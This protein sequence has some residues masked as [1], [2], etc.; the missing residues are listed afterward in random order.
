[1]SRWQPWTT[2]LG[3]RRAVLLTFG[4]L[5]AAGAL[6]ASSR[7]GDW[8]GSW[9]M[10][11]ATGA[12]ATAFVG[13]VA[14]GV[15]CLVYARLRSSAMSEVL[16]QSR[17]DWLRWLQPLLATWLLAFA[18]LVVVT[19]ATT[20]I[21]W[22]SGVPAYPEYLWIVLPAGGVLAAQTAIGAALGHA[23]GR[24]WTAPLAVVLVFLLLLWTLTGPMPEFFDTGLVSS[25]LAGLRFVPEPWLAVGAAGLLLAV[26][27]VGLAHRSLFLATAGRRVLVGLAALGWVATWWAVDSDAQFDFLADPQWTCAGAHP[28]VCV[29]AETPRPLADLAARVDRQAAALR[30]LD[31]ALPARFVQTLGEQPTGTGP[32]NLLESAS[33]RTVP[34]EIA[35]DALTRPTSC[36]ADTGAGPAHLSFEARHLL[37]RWLQ[38]RAGLLEPRPD[39]ADRAWLTG[40]PA[41]ADAWVRTTYVQLTAC[42]YD[43]LRMPDGLG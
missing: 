42:A 6:V 13:P 18:A 35:T 2:W 14:A 39:D 40:D 16:R 41:V 38:V 12:G 36:P 37:G 32:I 15:A 10:A 29:H 7:I 21:A 5:V 1:M 31:V 24:A 27:V 34:D 19:A 26:C 9:K 4:L 20:T 28:E 8:R 22:R 43:Q 25:D 17:R 30:A 11:L 3:G 33:R 23:S